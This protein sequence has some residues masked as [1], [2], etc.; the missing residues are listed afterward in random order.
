MKGD[1]FE[2]LFHNKSKIISIRLINLNAK[3]KAFRLNTTELRNIEMHDFLMTLQRIASNLFMQRRYVIIEIRS[4]QI[5]CIE[6]M[7]LPKSSKWY[8]NYF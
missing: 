4:C 5:T 1:K 8:W 6:S 7:V 3:N 2:R